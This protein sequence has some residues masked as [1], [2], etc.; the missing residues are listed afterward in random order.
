MTLT[1]A[2]ALV[3]STLLLTSAAGAQERFTLS[4]QEV[5]VYNLAGYG[6]QSV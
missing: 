2:L 4:G 1:R 3:S 6:L 5:S